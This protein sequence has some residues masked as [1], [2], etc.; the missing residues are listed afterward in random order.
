MNI[1]Y[2]AL[3]RQLNSLASLYT[4]CYEVHVINLITNR[5]L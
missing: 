4:E 3:F 2:L 1:I 5:T